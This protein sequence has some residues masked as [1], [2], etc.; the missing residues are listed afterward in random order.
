MVNFRLTFLDYRM[1]VIITSILKEDKTIA[2]DFD[3]DYIY[4]IPLD[5]KL[6]GWTNLMPKSTRQ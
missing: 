4:I 2:Q 1:M 6:P 3:I 5:F